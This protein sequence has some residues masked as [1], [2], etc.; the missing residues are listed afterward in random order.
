MEN[1]IATTQLYNDV[2]HIIEQGRQNAY[3][4]V[5]RSMIETYWRIGQRIVEEEQQ[6]KERAEYGEKIIENLSKQLTL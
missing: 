1:K 3:A 6:G 4:A 2:C 5:N